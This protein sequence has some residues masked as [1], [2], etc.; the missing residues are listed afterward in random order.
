M[1][2]ALYLALFIVGACGVGIPF[3]LVCGCI[4]FEAWWACGCILLEAWWVMIGEWKE[5]MRGR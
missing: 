5:V 4:L 3:L 2:E 1:M